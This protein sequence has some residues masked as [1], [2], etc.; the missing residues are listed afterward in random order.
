MQI[1][2]QKNRSFEETGFCYL[3]MLIANRHKNQPLVKK[4]E[5]REKK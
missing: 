3:V 4:E 1:K 5:A 2:Q